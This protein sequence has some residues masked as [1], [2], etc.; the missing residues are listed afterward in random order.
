MYSTSLAVGVG[1]APFG[2]PILPHGGGASYN[3]YGWYMGSRVAPFTGF[4][5]LGINYGE[6]MPQAGRIYGAAVNWATA[7]ISRNKY[8][9][10][11]VNYGPGIYTFPGMEITQSSGG[12]PI[13]GGGN[14]R[15]SNRVWDEPISFLS[16]DYI[17]MYIVPVGGFSSAGSQIKDPIEIEGTIYFRF[18]NTEEV[19]GESKEASW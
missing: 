5:P 16:G 2:W 9:I 7:N 13:S 18:N 1:G 4:N 12:I 3:N 10:Y 14:W 6:Y 15:G 8:K 17:G 19:H 11:A